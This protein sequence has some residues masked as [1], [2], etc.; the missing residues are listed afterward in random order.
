MY[1]FYHEGFFGYS[2]T[3]DFK[4]FSFWHFLPIVLMIISIICIYKNKEKIA[5]WKYEGTFR[6]IYAFIMIIVEMSYYWRLVYVG[7]DKGEFTLMNRLPIQICQWGIIIAAFM[8]MSKNQKLYSVSY[9][10]TLFFTPIALVYPMVIYNTG[11][12]YYRYYQYWLEHIMPIIAVFYMKFVYGYKPNYKGL[13]MAY[14]FLW[15]IAILSVIANNRI[16]H[17]VYLYLDVLSFLNLPQ[18]VIILILGI[19]TF[20]VFNIEYFLQKRIY[21]NLDAKKRTN[22]ET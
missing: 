12:S 11:P 18:Y 4:M 20:A 1:K 3:T 21:A 14:S 19:I 2:L 9:F 13:L 8:L 22:Q 10:I 6:F 16:E 15:F 7:D 5:K 17:A